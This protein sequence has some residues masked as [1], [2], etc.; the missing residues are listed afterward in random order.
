MVL[1][2]VV[3][4]EPPFVEDS[5]L[6]TE[7]VCPLKVIVPLAELAQPVDTAGESEPPTE[8]GLTVIVTEA[9]EEA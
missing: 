4:F 5:H 2:I 3:Q 7:P 8:A 1:L 6:I 9:Q